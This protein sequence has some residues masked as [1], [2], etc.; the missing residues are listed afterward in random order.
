MTEAKTKD[1]NDELKEIAKEIDKIIKNNP[2][3]H[4]PQKMLRSHGMGSISRFTGSKNETVVNVTRRGWLL[5]GLIIAAAGVAI[6]SIVF[7]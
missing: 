7:L 3:S 6:V 5:I 1:F 2:P 4:D